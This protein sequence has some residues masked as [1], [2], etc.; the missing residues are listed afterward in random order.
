MQSKKLVIG[1]LAHVDAGKT[2]LAENIL[3]L[4][5]AIKQRG[6]V[7]HKDAFLD[8][9]EL[10]K[11]RGI[12]IFSKQAEVTLDDRMITLLDTPGHVD[13][14]AEM[15]R[16]L[17][18]LDY[19]VLVISGMDGV[20]GH[21]TTL[22]SLLKRYEI[23]TFIFINKMDQQG[24]DPE[25]LLDELQ[26]RLSESCISFTANSD[27]DFYE[28][29]AMSDELVMEQYL[30]QGSIEQKEIARLVE[31]RKVFP[32]Y[33]GSALKNEG[34]DALL[35]GLKQY[36]KFKEYPEEFGAKIYKIS[37]DSQG[38]RLT[39]LKITGG[40]L[41]VKM[42]LSGS[43]KGMEVEEE[44]VDQIR[45]YSGDQYQVEPEVSA[46]AVCAVT[47]L[48]KSYVGAGLGIEPS[49]DKVVLEPVLTYGLCL[50]EGCDV[51]GMYTKMCQLEEEDPQLHVVWD[52]QND[53]IRVQVMGEVQIEILQTLIAQRFDVI[54]TFTAGSIVYKETI[55]AATL[56]MGH[57]E[58]LR[59]Y[60]EVHVL[61]EPTKRGSGITY[62]TTCSED[63][64]DKNWQRLILTHLQERKH[65]G[66]LIG[67]EVTDLAI[68]LVAGRA[69]QKHTEGGDFRQATYRAVRQG[70]KSTKS[71]L[72]EPVY[73]YRLEVPT[74]KVGR[75][76]SDIQKMSGTFSPPEMKKDMAVI[77]GRA[78]VSQMRDYQIEVVSYTRGLG[79]FSC[80]PGGYEECHNAEE[81]IAASGY[82]SEEDVDNPTG[83]VFCTHGSGFLVEW[84]KVEAYAHVDSGITLKGSNTETDSKPQVK[85]N[86]RTSSLEH[87]TDK[88]LEEIFVR[89]YGEIDRRSFSE[90][91]K[92]SPPIKKEKEFVYKKKEPIEQ[93]LLVDGYNIIFAWEDLSELA[94]TNIASARDK[95]S[96]ILCNYQGYKKNTVIL[97]YDAYKVPGF[98]GEIQKYKNIYVVYTKQ[99]ETAD[100]YIER[101]VHQ[102]GRKYDVTVATSDALE[103]MIIWGLGAMRL[104]AKGLKEEVEM[105]NQEIRGEYLEKQQKL[106][107]YLLKGEQ[108][109]EDSSM[110]GGTDEH[111]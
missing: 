49:S 54:V 99:A 98:Q 3:Y 34:V 110:E 86:N 104:S 79:R 83:S 88:E 70:L 97:V 32:C 38:N 28:N 39:H 61:L 24:A 15:E 19:A 14:S 23:P 56:G 26:S 11:L 71:V 52:E 105:V 17:Q 109:W 74:D 59:H 63:V 68:T 91:H 106:G 84:D 100:Q 108:I 72:L 48:R 80:S 89:T 7:D 42:P 5:G 66:V 103:Q 58:P 47:G 44:K 20:Q 21:V 8:T 35:D 69:H 16:T 96:E 50:P 67:A 64:L 36:T 27:H 85:E 107:N 78:P 41:K 73:E 65:P 18:V 29:L 30:E 13:F 45:I 102:I 31:T 1:I 76:L 60:A 46:G 111:K 93:Y 37:R 9:F 75:A 55:S 40:S 94:K 53:Q 87:V 2:T 4:S 10:E 51:H 62:D 12:T 90:K 6:R 101:T 57:F 95:L 77:T 22:W 92:Q 82:D 81:I 33:F 25:K 43:R